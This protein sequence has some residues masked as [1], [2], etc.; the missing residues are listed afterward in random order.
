[1][2]LSPTW[3]Q[4]YSFSCNL[5]PKPLCSYVLQNPGHLC[6]IEF[7]GS[8]YDCEHFR[9]TWHLA[10]TVSLFSLKLLS[11][12]YVSWWVIRSTFTVGGQIIITVHDFPL[13]CS[14]PVDSNI[15]MSGRDIRIGISRI[16]LHHLTPFMSRNKVILTLKRHI[17][18][19]T[20]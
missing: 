15:S 19:Y 11:G 6:Q 10:Y 4:N 20:Q 1:M 9:K 17:S 8:A 16:F 18:S 14:V 7:S 5:Q 13:R 12:T 3:G 2:S